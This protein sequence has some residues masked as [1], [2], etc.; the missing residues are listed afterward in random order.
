MH[1]PARNSA[2]TAVTTAA[3]TTAAAMIAVA[4]MIAADATVAAKH[5]QSKVTHGSMAQKQGK[6]LSFQCQ[7]H[8]A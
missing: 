3:A 5:T 6:L 2:T 1:V 8:K 4:V 7:H